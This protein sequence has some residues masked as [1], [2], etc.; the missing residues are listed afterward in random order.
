M[1][2][3]IIKYLDTN[4]LP[5]NKW[6]AKKVK[7]RVAR[8]TL[9]YRVLCRQGYSMPLLRCVSLEASACVV[10]SARGNLR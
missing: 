4:E 6:E 5:I 1:G 9:I 2:S 3:D 7:N 10:R 8:F